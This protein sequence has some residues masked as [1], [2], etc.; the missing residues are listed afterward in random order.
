MTTDP[1][2]SHPQCIATAD[3]VVRK[4]MLYGSAKDRE[5][6]YQIRVDR[7]LE[8]DSAALSKAKAEQRK[9]AGRVPRDY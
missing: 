1:S 8:F 4:L 2:L 7:G 9:L 3:H 5:R 6:A